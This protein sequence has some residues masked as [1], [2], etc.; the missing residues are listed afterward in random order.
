MT[1]NGPYFFF[2]FHV[3]RETQKEKKQIKYLT[4]FSLTIQNFPNT[5]IQ[6]S[7]TINSKNIFTSK[8]TESTLTRNKAYINNLHQSQKQTNPHTRKRNP[9]TFAHSLTR[10]PFMRIRTRETAR[11]TASLS[12]PFLRSST[13]HC[14]HFTANI[15]NPGWRKHSVDPCSQRGCAYK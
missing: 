10:I 11:K 8:C 5:S 6:F 9:S 2:H 1:T 15:F 7:H 14:S 3:P 4:H 13:S 12:T